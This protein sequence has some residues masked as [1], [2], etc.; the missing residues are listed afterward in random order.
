VPKVIAKDGEHFKILLKKFKKS[1]ERAGLLSDIKKNKYFEK[2]T[3]ERRRKKKEAVRK[4]IKL[5]R[6]RRRF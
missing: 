2:P 3:V 6:K 1:C 5:M 4:Q